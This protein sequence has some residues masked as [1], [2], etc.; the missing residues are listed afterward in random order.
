MLKG[1]ISALCFLFAGCA[2]LAQADT[3]A[4]VAAG[5]LANTLEKVNS[6][7][8][9]FVSRTGNYSLR[10]DKLKTESSIKIYRNCGNNCRRFMDEIISHLGRATLANCST[11]QENILI[12]LGNSESIIYSHSGRMIEFEGKCYFN[13]KG[14]DSTIKSSKFLFN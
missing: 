2:P 9:Y 1:L 4:Q 11:G 3:G 6:V 14:I 8:F 13:E 10:E 5:R 12:D 7:S